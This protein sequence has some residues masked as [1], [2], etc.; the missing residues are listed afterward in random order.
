MIGRKQKSLP[1][2][3]HY[4]PTFVVLFLSK[5][6][7]ETLLFSIQSTICLVANNDGENVE[8][9]EMDPKPFLSSI[10]ETSVD[11]SVIYPQICFENLTVTSSSFRWM[12]KLSVLR[13]ER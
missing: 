1:V 6:L 12:I 3:G 10:S 9:N 8:F 4:F 2:I 13:F 11:S 5:K 7:F